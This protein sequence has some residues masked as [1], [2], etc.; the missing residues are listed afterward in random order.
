MTP[1]ISPSSKERQSIE[2][3]KRLL[4]CSHSSEIKV[5]VIIAYTFIMSTFFQTYAMT[6]FFFVIASIVAFCIETLPAMKTRDVSFE[7]VT[8]SYGGGGNQSTESTVAVKSHVAF[9]Y[10]DYVCTMFFSVEF[11]VRLVFAPSKT[12]FFC[13]VMNIIDILALLPLYVQVCNSVA[14]WLATM[15]KHHYIPFLLTFVMLHLQQC[16]MKR[17]EFVNMFY[18]FNY[19]V[20]LGSVD[21]ATTIAKLPR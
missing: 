20:Q 8:R 21:G 10:V 1:T 19:I 18:I 14:D 15:L 13:S 12:R 4:D 11:I 16:Q 6:S 9:E 7:D 3:I 5:N 2:R 17:R